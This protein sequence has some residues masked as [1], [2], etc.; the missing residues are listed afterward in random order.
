MCW[1]PGKLR[2]LGIWSG[3]GGAPRLLRRGWCLPRCPVPHSKPRGQAQWSQHRGAWMLRVQRA[4]PWPESSELSRSLS[5][6]L[7][8]P[9]LTDPWAHCH[10]R[11]CCRDRSV[12]SGGAGC[13]P[14]TS[15][16]G[17]APH[18]A[19]AKGKRGLRRCARVR[20]G[21][22]QGC[23]S[24]KAPVKKLSCSHTTGWCLSGFLAV[25]ILWWI[26]CIKNIYV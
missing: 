18:G 10:P 14:G 13:A 16:L 8:C 17:A 3:A 1:S 2:L 25:L 23:L 24:R 26:L 7:L 12:G 5:C 20:R 6:F 11:F 4:Q 9:L 19:G 22:H 15:C 21:R